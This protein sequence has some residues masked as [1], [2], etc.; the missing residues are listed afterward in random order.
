MNRVGVSAVIGALF[1]IFRFILPALAAEAT[2]RALIASPERFDHTIVTVRGTI[3]N[4]KSTVSR[5]G[6]PYYT[7][8]L[9]SGGQSVRVFSFGT[10]GCKDGLPVTV[11]GRF[12]RVKRVSGRTFYNEIDAMKIACQQ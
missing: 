9:S 12:D 4:L 8:D 5:R 3:T 11:E 7:F 1:L 2:P 10:P 6:N